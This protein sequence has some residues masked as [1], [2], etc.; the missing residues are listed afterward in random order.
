ME[1]FYLD[2]KDMQFHLRYLPLKDI[3][4]LKEG[5]FKDHEEFAYAPKNAE[6]ALVNYEKVLEVMGEICGEHIAPLAPEID[7][8]GAHLV[9]G[10]VHYPRGTAIALELIKR[11]GL[12]G[13]TV[14]RRYNGLN[15][16]MTVYT[17]LIELVAR[18][19]AG[20][21]NIFSLQDI[22]ETIYEY[23]DEDIRK[24]Y[25]TM[26]ANGEVTGAM[27]LTEAEAGSDLQRVKTKAILD[28]TDGTWRL[29]GTKRFITNGNAQ[30]SLVLARSE[31]GTSDARGLSMFLIERD[32][33]VKIRRIEDKLG[34]H[35]S[36]TCEMQFDGTKAL[37]IG[38]RKMGLIKYVMELMNGAR[39]GIAGQALGIAEAAYREALKY[40]HDRRQFL[41]SIIEFPAV[42]D[43][44]TTMRMKIE[45]ARVLTYYT[46]MTV[47]Y[48][49]IYTEIFEHE[50][51]PAAR[52]RMKYYT[53]V[54]NTM[55][56][57]AKFYSTEMANQV[58][59]DAIQIHGGDGYMKDYNVERHYRDARITN[60]YE[61][62]TQ[63]QVVAAIGGI[64]SGDIENE[65]HS[66]EKLVYE[67]QF[68]KEKEMVMT[69]RRQLTEMMHK[70]K[71]MDDEEKA[72]HARKLVNVATHCI[73]CYLML[74]DAQ[75]SGRKE[76][77]GR[78]FVRSAL[79]ISTSEHYGIMNAHRWVIN[80]KELIYSLD[81]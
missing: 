25:C 62:T 27:I 70:Y 66:L 21:M 60:I 49:K 79:G 9:D 57:I 20:L 35:G 45:A 5:N 81:Q 64:I 51:D 78:A 34:I 42:Y 6:E 15:F 56:P 58:T 31:E 13:I 77:I 39:L 3:I 74:N 48:K 10:D 14:P 33:T 1:N 63:L 40:A 80:E 29:Y 2:N 22:G 18:A 7:N 11:A 36:P 16:P 28:E 73:I 23:A 4:T 71:E 69:M 8:E 54:A 55:T 47:D 30:V 32:E 72:Y 52:E 24:K 59:Y 53:S 46:S 76:T 17:M 26:F 65:L 61:G 38:K 41:K 12:T 44:L 50:K 43:M 68:D 67:H 19:E 37:L 75:K